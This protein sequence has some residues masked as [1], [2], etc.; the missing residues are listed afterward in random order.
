MKQYIILFFMLFS[1]GVEKVSAQYG[2]VLPE[3]ECTQ[4]WSGNQ[5]GHVFNIFLPGKSAAPCNGNPIYVDLTVTYQRRCN[6]IRIIEVSGFD[7]DGLPPPCYDAAADAAV[8]NIADAAIINRS[9]N[10]LLRQIFD[11]EHPI[12][13]PPDP[14]PFPCP[15]GSISYSASFASCFREVW[16]ITWF[17]ANPVGG[18]PIMH[19]HDIDIGKS[20][21]YDANGNY[22]TYYQNQVNIYLIS[23]GVLIP[24]AV[25]TSNYFPCN[26]YC[27]IKEFSYCYDENR[28][29]VETLL[30]F[31]PASQTCPELEEQCYITTCTTN[32]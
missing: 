7:P 3:S 10:G 4:G 30:N 24:S 29:V 18:P 17:T 22:T 23:Q 26:D 21:H 19:T 1:V 28:E 16:T 9:I 6:E 12:P 5:F 25:V 27:C 20:N 2:C 13:P 14:N 8:F 32:P 11:S 31:Y 15:S